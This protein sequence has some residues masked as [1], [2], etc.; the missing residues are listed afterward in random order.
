ME[1]PGGTTKNQADFILSSNQKTVGIC[2]II[3][4]LDIDSDHRM[5]RVRVNINKTLMR[6]KISKNKN[7]SN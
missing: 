6:L 2:E 5:V 3:T 7:H 4:K 1:P